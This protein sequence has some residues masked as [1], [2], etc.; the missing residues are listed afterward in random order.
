[1]WLKSL[2]DV[3]GSGSLTAF[4]NARGK[5]SRQWSAP[6]SVHHCILTAAQGCVR[7]DIHLA[8]TGCFFARGGGTEI[9]GMRP[10]RGGHCTAAGKPDFPGTAH[11]LSSAPTPPTV[12]CVHNSPAPLFCSKSSVKHVPDPGE[13]PQGSAAPMNQN[14]EALKWA[15]MAGVRIR[16]ACS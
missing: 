2:C 14:Q 8:V 5:V 12:T 16:K 1:M 6:L 15:P 10:H 13:N 7:R 11:R 4:S 3:Q 9:P